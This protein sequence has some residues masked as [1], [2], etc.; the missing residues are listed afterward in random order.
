MLTPNID[1]LAKEG[2]ILERNYVQPSCTPSRSALMTGMYPYKIGRQGTP[3]SI[4]TPTGLFLNHTI[5]PE[6]LKQ[7]GYSTHAVGK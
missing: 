4:N 7:A 1:K 6:Y 3:L 5:F 2:G